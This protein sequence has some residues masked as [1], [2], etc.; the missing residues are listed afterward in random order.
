MGVT[1]TFSVITSVAFFG[2]FFLTILAYTIRAGHPDNRRILAT[3]TIV[4]AIIS[5]T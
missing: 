5:L 4:L 3:M 1:V 2:A